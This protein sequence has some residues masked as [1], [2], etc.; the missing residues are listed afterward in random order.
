LTV[1]AAELRS[2]GFD[3]NVETRFLTPLARHE[4]LFKSVP[5]LFVA[6]KAQ[7]LES[8]PRKN[9]QKNTIASTKM[10]STVVEMS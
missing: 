7:F 6:P 3:L 9:D 1:A 4:H 8:K 5:N 2:N 10:H